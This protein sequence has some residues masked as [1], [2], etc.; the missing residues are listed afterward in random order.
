MVRAILDGGIRDASVVEVVLAL[1][2]ALSFNSLMVALATRA[3]TDSGPLSFPSARD[4]IVPQAVVFIFFAAL[5]AMAISARVQS[6]AGEN[7]VMD[8]QQ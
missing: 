1:A 8:E 4:W 7:E 2:T 5:L 3:F 6:G